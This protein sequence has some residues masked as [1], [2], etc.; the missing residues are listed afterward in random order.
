MPITGPETL[1]R[2]QFLSGCAGCAACAMCGTAAP[3]PAAPNDKC[4]VRLVFAHP[5][6]TRQGWP[7]Q[8]YDYESRKK[9]LTA[10]LSAACPN[11]AFLPAASK[12]AEDTAQILKDDGEV[13]GYLVYLL[14]I[15]ARVSADIAAAGRPT[16]LVDDLYG[17][18]GEFLTNFAALKRKGMKVAGVS[19]TRFQD[20]VDAV[21]VLE[22]LKR[23]RSDV[24]LDV[25]EGDL[26][27]DA[28]GIQENFGVTVRQT[29]AEEINTAYETADLA[30]ARKS[31][32][33]WIQHAEKI[34]EPSRE[35]IGKSGRMHVAM[36]GLMQRHNAR[37]ITIDCLRL[38]YGGKLPAYPCLGLF[39]FN[40]DG[41]VGACEADLQS[42]ITMLAMTTLTGR[43]GYISDPVIDT[44]KNQIIYAHCVAPSKVYGPSGPENPYHFVGSGEPLPH[45]RPF[46]RSQRRLRAFAHASG[47]DHHHAE[48]PPGAKR[49]RHASGQNCC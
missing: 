40:N 28:K 30:E 32:A 11:T 47:R 3:P 37:A 39:Q 9:E 48:I 5:V 14:G 23:L 18:T 36:R 17:G 46:R 10:R 43:P 22:T 8:G 49:S 42:T 31:A 38:F 13:D 44:S 4:R 20:V 1:N 29:S 26:G 19:S 24:I 12:G 21:R 45:P 35:E 25:R 33:L 7:Y 15:P 27:A 41:L 34:V 6:P 2:R 16:I